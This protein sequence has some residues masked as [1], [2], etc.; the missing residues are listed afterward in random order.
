MEIKYGLISSD[1]HGQLGKDAYTSRMS[2]TKWGDRVPHVIEVREERFNSPVERWVVNGEIQGGNVCN[3]PTAMGNRSYYPQRWEEVPTEVYDPVNR[4]KALDRDRVDAEVLFPNGP[5]GTF[6]YGDA[7]FELACVRAYNDALAEFRNVSER[8]IPLAVIPFMS[9]METIVAEVERAVKAGHNGIN[10]LGDP[11]VAVKG[12]KNLSDPFWYPLWDACQQLGVGI[13]L[14][15]SA[16]LAGKLSL[17]QW[18]GYSRRQSHC[19]STLRN[20]CTATQ[21]IP[22]L[23]FSGQLDRFPRLIWVF[24]ETGLGWV[25]SVLEA[26]DH[27]WEKRHLWTEGILSRPSELFRR[28]IYVD[29]WFETVGIHLR[30]YIGVDNILWESDFPH[31]TSTYPNSWDA[32]EHSLAG[33]SNAEREKILF[34]NAARLYKLI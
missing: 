3:C 16:G 32:V 25:S 22:Y 4:L 34:R 33:V 26:C 19:V 31:I 5:G 14:H 23:I 1:S 13:H 17:P 20:F 6:F 8:F 7:E 30:E 11:S 27:E 2:R 24:A 12:L 21:I 9:P 29:F 18:K 28:Q 10:M 15:A